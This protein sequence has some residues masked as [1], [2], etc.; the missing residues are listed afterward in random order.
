MASDKII[1]KPWKYKNWLIWP[2]TVIND[3]YFSNCID[4]VDGVCLKN[5]SIEECIESCIGDCFI[6]YHVT[7]PDKSTICVPIND[8]GDRNINPLYM[9]KPQ[10]VL[11]LKRVEVSTFINTD[12]IPFPP[13]DIDT[14]FYE[15]D[16]NMQSVSNDQ[17]IGA[18]AVDKINETPPVLSLDKFKLNFLTVNAENE[19]LQRNKKLYY[20]DQVLINVPDTDIILTKNK[21]L[22]WNQ[23]LQPFKNDNY[24]TV[25]SKDG[26][27]GEVKIND[28]IMLETEG[29][30]LKS[31]V[32]SLEISQL[33]DNDSSFLFRINSMILGYY[34]EGDKC[35]KGDIN[36]VKDKKHA[37]RSPFCLNLCKKGSLDFSTSPPKNKDWIYI[38][39][40]TIILVIIFV[41][42]C[43]LI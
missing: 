25:K 7:L 27:K 21:G 26:K 12:K 17:Y 16:I 20:G 39:V 41:L 32:N 10:S 28:E 24:F 11:E 5:K 36:S 14:I 1:N 13:K 8:L 19:L 29:E 42:L 33:S 38:I 23:I 22:L 37:T 4:A 9:L 30:F 35:K 34:C 2:N 6:G 3:L 43:V 18:K 40:A 31:N 15:D